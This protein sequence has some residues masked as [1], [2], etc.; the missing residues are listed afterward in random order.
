MLGPDTRIAIIPPYVA[1]YDYTEDTVMILR[2]V[3]GRQNITAALI[4]RH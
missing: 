1:I 4:T 3:H 2:V